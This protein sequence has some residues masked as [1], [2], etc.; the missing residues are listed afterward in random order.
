M[1]QIATRVPKPHHEIIGAL[2]DERGTSHSEVARTL[3]EDQLRE[4]GLLEGVDRKVMERVES[5]QLEED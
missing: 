4:R 2:A 1:E 5:K 3:I